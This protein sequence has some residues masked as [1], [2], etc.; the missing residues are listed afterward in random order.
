MAL[1]ARFFDRVFFEQGIKKVTLPS[2]PNSLYNTATQKFTDVSNVE[3]PG[4]ES[5]GDVLELLIGAQAD[6]PQ[7]AADVPCHMP[8]FPTEKP[9]FDVGRTLHIPDQAC[10]LFMLLSLG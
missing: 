2:K 7:Q 5:E 8:S 10:S 1:A 6:L 3:L 4:K 9:P